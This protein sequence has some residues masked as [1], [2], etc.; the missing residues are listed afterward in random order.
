LDGAIKNF[1]NNYNVLAPFLGKIGNKKCPPE[2]MQLLPLCMD[3][4]QML[5][6]YDLQ[7]NIILVAHDMGGPVAR[8]LEYLMGQQLLGVVYINSMGA[9]LFAQKVKRPEQLVRSGYMGLFQLPVFTSNMMNKFGRPI[10]N[11]AYARGQAKDAL[12]NFD[13]RWWEGLE[14]YRQFWRSKVA[15]PNNSAK[16]KIPALFIWGESDPFITVPKKSDIA[17]FYLQ[18]ALRVFEGGHWI[19]QTHCDT[20]NHILEKSFYEWNNANSAGQGQQDTSNTANR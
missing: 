2:R 18:F 13:P 9:D 3:I 1:E 17:P 12:K 10:L 15:R 19:H 11:L 20:L 14:F 8:E 5:Q 4:M 16:S 6:W 7:R